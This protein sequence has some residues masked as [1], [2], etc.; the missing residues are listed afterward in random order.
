M[1]GRPRQA[2]AV[3]QLRPAAG[4][5]GARCHDAL[6]AA[7]R[8][9]ISSEPLQHPRSSA[10]LGYSRPT[11]GVNYS[12]AK[13]MHRRA[14]P[15]P[16]PTDVHQPSPFAVGSLA[17]RHLGYR[18][19]WRLGLRLGGRGR[20]CRS[21]RG[22][23]RCDHSRR[24]RSGRNLS[25]G[26]NDLLLGFLLRPLRMAA[27]FVDYLF[28]W[29]FRLHLAGVAISDEQNRPSTCGIDLDCRVGKPWHLNLHRPGSSDGSIGCFRLARLPFR[30]KVCV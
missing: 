9:P 2:I 25:R 18:V 26:R 23:R 22:H 3:V 7:G 15:P 19:R 24:R 8:V 30:G 17:G 21:G 14:R 5:Q 12:T 1:S 4:M 29:D 27:I 20:G 28:G 16:S 10:A 6:P 11:S 13:R